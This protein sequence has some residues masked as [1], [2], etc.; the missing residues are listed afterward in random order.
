MLSTVPRTVMLSPSGSLPAKTTFEPVTV[1]S[2]RAPLRQSELRLELPMRCPCE[3]ALMTT[4]IVKAATSECFEKNVPD[5]V[6]LTSAGCG[7]EPDS[8]VSGRTLAGGLLGTLK[9]H[10]RHK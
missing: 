3:S 5:H 2:R 6:P 8:G 7:V 4:V 10:N 1:T 9:K